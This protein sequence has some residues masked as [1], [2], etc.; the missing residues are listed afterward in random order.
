MEISEGETRFSRLVDE[1]GRKGTRVLVEKSGTPVAALVSTTD[2]DRLAQFDRERSALFEAI[3][4]R[5]EGFTGV[6]N[7]EIDRAADHAV[8]SFGP[9]LPSQRGTEA[10]W[11][12]RVQA[13]GHHLRHPEGRGRRISRRGGVVLEVRVEVGERFFACGLRMTGLGWRHQV[14]TKTRNSDERAGVT[15]ARR[16]RTPPPA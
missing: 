3:D 8:L 2:L 16:L 13:P 9:R 15:S 1:V 4:R 11:L 6:P 7:E 10:K 14:G 5:R 12:L